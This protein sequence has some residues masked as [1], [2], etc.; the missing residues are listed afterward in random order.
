VDFVIA[1]DGER[2]MLRLL[3]ALLG[4]GDLATVPNLWYRR[5]GRP[6]RSRPH[7][8]AA[9]ESDYRGQPF[10]PVR[11][12]CAYDCVHCGVGQTATV[13][14]F[15]TRARYR[16][17]PEKVASEILPL[18]G[19]TGQAR[20]AGDPILTFGAGG[21]RRFCAAVGARG[22]DLDLGLEFQVMHGEDEIG[23][24]SRTFRSVRVSLRPDSGDEEVRRRQGKPYG[25][26]DLVRCVAAA[27][28]RGNVTVAVT[29][30]F[31]LAGDDA[32][33]LARSLA[34]ARHLLTLETQR[35][36]ELSFQELWYLHPGSR[37]FQD[38]EAYGYRADWRDLSS[39]VANLAAPLFAGAVHFAPAGLSRRAYVELLLRKHEEFNL[40]MGEHGRRSAAVG[41]HVRAYVEVVGEYLAAYERFGPGGAGIAA[42]EA[43]R[44]GDAMRARFVERALGVGGPAPRVVASQASSET[45]TGGASGAVML[46]DARRAALLDALGLRDRPV[47]RVLCGRGEVRV[48][49]PAGALTVLPAGSRTGVTARTDCFDLCAEGPLDPAVVPALRRLEETA[50]HRLPLLFAPMQER[51]AR[52]DPPRAAKV[53]EL[54][55]VTMACNQRCLFCSVDPARERC[56]EPAEVR[57]FIEGRAGGP[58]IVFSGG[59]PT[60]DE[61][62]PEYLAAAPAAGYPEVVIQTNAVRCAYPAYAQKL[63]GSGLGA[64]FVSLH[65]HRARTSD[66]LTRTPGSF[67][68]TLRGIDALMAAGV[69]VWLNFVATAR[70]IG[71][72]EAFVRF[73][74]ARFPG[75]A[76]VCLSLV[77]PVGEG[78]RQGALW[79]RLALAAP[80]VAAALDAASRAGIP[81]KVPDV[82]GL[83]LCLL[84]GRERFSEALRALPEEGAAKP[85]RIHAAACA[86]CRWRSVC[87]GFWR[88]YLERYGAK[89][90][91]PQDGPPPD[92]TGATDGPRLE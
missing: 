70:T 40:L 58:F 42:P 46:G 83:P 84:A 7:Y 53:E 90:L 91:V 52:P 67:D 72:A 24:L 22:A 68:L 16:Y 9:E 69:R 56:H 85:D 14:L 66:A 31:G 81:A 3:E 11:R 30:T 89:E 73:A 1:G 18:A 87:S 12:G 79:P 55:R 45:F 60:L 41:Q 63:V 2:P 10:V 25:N 29:F 78:A 17:A 34:L 92:P 33:S 37:A 88:P 50:P 39:F 71:D 26:D 15:G 21:M 28:A 54:V 19:A 6:V 36:L 43:R 8:S 82:C 5:H 64:A 80:H 51:P 76:G 44:L 35:P 47:R 86:E 13:A 32:R 61:R 65:S 4:G 62:L 23:R 27:G 57:A 38:P 75:Y 59:E 20:L 48:E 49:L 77:A 74:A